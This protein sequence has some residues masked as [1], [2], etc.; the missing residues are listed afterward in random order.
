MKKFRVFIL[1][2]FSYIFITGFT[3]SNSESPL[4]ALGL[5]GGLIIALIT[6]INTD[7]ALIILIFS[8]LLSPEI[9]I[10]QVPERAVV[11][12][13]DDILVVFMFF[14]W[15]A[16]MAINK[17]LGFLKKTPIN[18]PLAAYVFL[19]IF[20]TVLG[21]IHGR[22]NPLTS[23]FY[24]LKYTEYFMIFFIFA[25]NIRTIKQVKVLNFVLLLTCVFV[26]AY[27][28]STR[29][30]YGRVTAPF[31]GRKGEGGAEPNT[32]GG[33]LVLLSGVTMGQLLYSKSG[34]YRPFLLGLISLIIP[35]LIFTFSRGGYAGFIV[36]Y[37]TLIFFT[38]KGKMA[39]VSI[40]AIAILLAIFTPQ[41]IPREMK[42]RITDTFSSAGGEYRVLGGT[43]RLDASSG[44][45]VR[46][47]GWI[48]EKFQR[49]PFFGWG[50]T[51]L[52][53][54]DQQYA[55]ILGEVGLIGMAVFIWLMITIFR[56]AL[57]IKNTLEIEEHRGLVIGFIAGFAGILCHSLAAN[58]FIIVRIMEP[59]W[60][61]AAAVI[62][63]NELSA[64]SVSKE[65]IT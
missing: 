8:M 64:P 49:H 44:W 31:E 3:A 21:I 16:K 40:L 29:S 4:L 37:L 65:E 51:G 2:L 22:I 14:T 1:I 43:V 19:Y 45:R 53:L 15:L 36:M 50:V 63:L 46:V 28:L 41:V 54:V 60:F 35:A 38:K 62:V 32:L 61:L 58:I 57:R 56:N 34:T 10:I 47:W 5:V 6:L 25:N 26:C 55:L 33:Y 11:L 24:I 30:Q 27:A 23:F 52:G 9:T 13:I 42:E 17:Q 7:L 18:R 12:R 48:F 59:F 39:L 20:S